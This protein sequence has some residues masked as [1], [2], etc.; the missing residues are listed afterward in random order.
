MSEDGKKSA[1]QNSEMDAKMDSGQGDDGTSVDAKGTSRG[2]FYGR[3]SK[4]TRSRPY[5]NDEIDVQYKMDH[6]R[7]GLALIFNHEY[8]HWSVGMNRRAGTQIDADN[9]QERFGE[10]GFDVS[11]NQDLGV[12]RIREKIIE[13]AR[14]D[15]TNND[16]F[17]CV[18][19]THGDDGIVYAHDGVI[20][21]QDLIDQFRADRCPTLAGKPKIFFIQACRGD[22]HEV[23]VDAPDEPDAAGVP[24]EPM[25][26]VDAGTQPTIPAGADF[27]VAYSVTQG[28][29]SHRDTHYGSWF[30]QAL[31]YVLEMYGEEIEIGEMMA[32]VNRMVTQRQVERALNPEMIGKKQVPCYLSMLTKKLY[33]TKKARR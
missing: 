24:D 30:I 25:T 11:L 9:L 15:H 12:I 5:M 20:K 2:F 22:Q 31:S 19:L 8:F 28:Y 33:F 27:F 32:L 7:R 16:A 18:F 17:V 23:G 21:L 14:A 10:L 6:P 1:E 26:V 29:Y 3:A 13:A 4:G